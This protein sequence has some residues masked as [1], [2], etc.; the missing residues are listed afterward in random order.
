MPKMSM[1]IP[2]TLGQDEA[3]SRVEG[4]ISTMKDQYGDRVSDLHEEWT[5][6]TGRFS[7]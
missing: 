4:M 5:G 3:R 2:H 7:L 1:T 6:D